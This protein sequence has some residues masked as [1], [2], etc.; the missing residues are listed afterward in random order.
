MNVAPR[1]TVD[2]D[3]GLA[4]WRQVHDQLRW[5]VGAGRLPVGARLPTVRQLARDLGLAPGTVARA[6]RELE[7][8][9]VLRTAG[10][11][12]TEVAAAPPGP[13]LQPLGSA[14][15]AYA[16]AARAAGADLQHAIAAVVAAFEGADGTANE[17]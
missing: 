12:G 15:A 8:V 11:N 9:G 16:A 10:R 4:A 14:A 1:I 2:P 13:R 5:L 6:Y 17:R 7:S 3:S